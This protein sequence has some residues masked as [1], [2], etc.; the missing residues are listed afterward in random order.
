M[1]E[2][3]SDIDDDEGPFDFAMLGIVELPHKDDI[4]RTSS[5]EDHQ[6]AAEGIESSEEEESSSEKEA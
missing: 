1:S 2:E 4:K 6:S 5:Q 3:D